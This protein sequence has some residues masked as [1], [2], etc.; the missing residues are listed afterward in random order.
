MENTSGI[1]ENSIGLCRETASV[2]DQALLL[3]N[4]GTLGKSPG[5][6]ETGNVLFLNLGGEFMGVHFSYSLYMIVYVYIIYISINMDV[7]I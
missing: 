5:F 6:E 2:Q 7:F 3:T 4:S 1:S